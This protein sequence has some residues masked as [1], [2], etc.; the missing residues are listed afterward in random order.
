MSLIRRRKK[1]E[2]G[3]D[4]WMTL[5]EAAE[6]LNLDESTI[7]RGE[8]P[9]KRRSMYIPVLGTSLSKVGI[10]GAEDGLRCFRCDL[11]GIRL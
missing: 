10:C 4:R 6:L 8:S 5:R 2:P 1:V 7:R 3:G 11:E 9:L